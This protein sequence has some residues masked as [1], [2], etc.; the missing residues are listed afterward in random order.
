ML[1]ADPKKPIAAKPAS[2]SKLTADVKEAIKAQ[3]EALKGV[4]KNPKSGSAAKALKEYP[5]REKI[6]SG[7]AAIHKAVTSPEVVKLSP[8]LPAEDVPDLDTAFAQKLQRAVA[9]GVDHFAKLAHFGGVTINGPAAVGT[10]GCLSGPTIAPMISYA[11]SVAGMTGAKAA[12]RDAVAK[13]F[14]DSFDL[15]RSS[16]II[17]GLPLYPAFLAFPGPVAPPMPNV[18]TPLSALP[19]VVEAPGPLKS[20]MIAALPQSLDVAAVHGFL[21]KLAQSLW[22]SFQVW[23]VQAMVTSMMGT[24][25]VPTFSPPFVPVGPVVGGHVIPAPGHLA[26]APSM[27]ILP[28]NL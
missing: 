6:G 11:S 12:L 19:G 17:P 2:V 16:V 18:P 15:W 9:E 5:T 20:R 27:P 1:K 13:G 14:S 7:K 3:T 23:R 21:D 28:V 4:L 25:P 22:M 8:A 10:P 24:G 26:G